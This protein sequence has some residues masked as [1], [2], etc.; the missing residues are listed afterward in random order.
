VLGCASQPADAPKPVA[1]AWAGTAIRFR[2]EGSAVTELVALGI[3]C[4]MPG[5]ATPVDVP[6]GSLPIAT[7]GQLAVKLGDIALQGRFTD[8]AS[9]S[10][11]FEFSPGCCHVLLPWSASP[12]AAES[13]DCTTRAHIAPQN[14]SLVPGLGMAAAFQPLVPGVPVQ[15][16]WGIQGSLMVV[17]GIDASGFDPRGMALTV[18]IQQGGV[19]VASAQ[20]VK[21]RWL[22]TPSGSWRAEPLYVI[23]NRLPEAMVGQP[24]VVHAELANRCGFL[25][26]SQVAVAVQAP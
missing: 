19:A 9:A 26:A 1:G 25:L 21:S 12:S 23:A 7:G 5:C 8:P 11:S 3:G 17:L 24:A 16:E 4:G 18:E 22:A 6:L 10:G 20:E 13:I 15:L 14:A 2:V